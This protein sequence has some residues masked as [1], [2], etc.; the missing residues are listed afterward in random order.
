M[1]D[2]LV[3]VVFVVICVWYCLG[4]ELVYFLNV[5]WN[6]LLLVKFSFSVSLVKFVVLVFSCVM[7]RLW[8]IWFFSVW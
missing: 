7:V 1:F 2:D 3:D 5:L 8:W 6:V 4:V